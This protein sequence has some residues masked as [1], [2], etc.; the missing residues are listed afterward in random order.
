M[1]SSILLMASFMNPSLVRIA[2]ISNFA[3]IN[4]NKTLVALM[5]GIP[6]K[7]KELNTSCSIHQVEIMD[8]I[9]R[10]FMSFE[11]LVKVNMSGC[12]FSV[13][14][15]RVW[16]NFIMKTPTL[17]DLNVSRCKITN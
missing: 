12:C 4:F 2:Y 8:Q 11:D 7:I 3:K 16:S 10:S 17:K 9:M 14:A 13:N 1:M 6:G 15:C 5:K